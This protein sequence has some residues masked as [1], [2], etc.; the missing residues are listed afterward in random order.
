[1]KHHIPSLSPILRF[2]Q[3]HYHW[4]THS[5]FFLPVDRVYPLPASLAP[6]EHAATQEWAR[7]TLPQT[8]GVRT[9]GDLHWSTAVHSGNLLHVLLSLSLTLLYPH[10]LS[11]RTWVTPASGPLH[12]PASLPG[13]RKA[14]HLAPGTRSGLP[15][16]SCHAGTPSHLI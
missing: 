12:L 5:I 9:K 8:S 4:L 10:P 16:R 1:M 11:I 3:S 2:L 7:H 13:I 15:P 14:S 6:L